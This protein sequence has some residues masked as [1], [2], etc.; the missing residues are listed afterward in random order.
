MDRIFEFIQNLTGFGPEAQAKLLQSIVIILLLGAV[1]WSVHRVL[2]RRVEDVSQRYYWTR[3]TTYTIA[4]IGI[5]MV[6]RVWFSGIGSVIEYLGIVS[7]GL[8]IA[9]HEAVAN[10]A[11]WGFILSRRP[12]QVGDRI[13]IGENAGDVIDIRLFQFSVLEIRNWVDA[14]QSTGRILHIPNGKVFRETLA[15]FTRGFNF[16][17]HEIPVLITFESN[18]QQAEEIL[19]GMPRSS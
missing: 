19:Q 7:A 9:M 10:L 12:F 15:N 17:W 6:A 13:Q 18:W 1:R 14:D 4:V 8:V 11:G 2:R 3:V 5:L 16:V